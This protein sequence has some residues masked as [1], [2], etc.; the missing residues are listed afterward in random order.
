VNAA[1]SVLIVDDDE[2]FR[3]SL[4]KQLRRDF[5]NVRTAESAAG[6][7]ARIEESEPDV[8]LMDLHLG[9]DDGLE[10]ME[11]VA[12][13]APST[14]IIVVTGF[15]TVDAAVSAMRRGAFDFVTKPL[16]VEAL[17]QAIGRA[18]ER[19]E[20][21]RENV[22]LKRMLHR[23]PPIEL[24]GESAAMR[25]VR[26]L[27]RGAAQS[28]ATVLISGP[29]GVGKELVAR[30]IH[31]ASPRAGREL[32]TVNC[33]A[34]QE[35]LLESEL[36]G[37]ERGAFTG[38]TEQRQGLIEAAH[39]GT[40]FLDEVGELPLSLQAKLL[41]A[42]QFN[43]IR[44]VGGT[45]TLKVDVRFLAATNRDLEA[46]IRERQFRED[47]YYRLNV[48]AIRVPPLRERPEDV[49]PILRHVARRAGLAW[50]P[51]EDHIA[52]LRA[53]PWPG[54]VREIENLVERL[55]IRE[56]DG[57]PTPERLLAL[58]GTGATAAP[59]VRKLEEV[60]RETI[61][62]ALEA[63]GGDRDEAARMLGIS[64]RKLYY[65]LAAYR[66]EQ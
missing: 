18:A 22:A 2:T 35:S 23:A 36:F 59:A 19:R 47:L 33:A 13:L 30:T 32:V 53:Y 3:T 48:I 55:K 27:A 9:S 38:A 64:V 37:H 5:G 11:R 65:R 43:E 50:E 45:A 1:V 61:E 41:R 56:G 57:V 17:V 25:E 66:G 39:R 31:R 42:L 63:A 52:A 58:L 20:L 21:R 28:D 34:L 6:C 24:L 44:R 14:E 40:L 16:S 51:R 46:A 4:A 7:L 54:N 12:A 10:A 15:G 26:E 8:V 49:E 62:R 60:E 29:S